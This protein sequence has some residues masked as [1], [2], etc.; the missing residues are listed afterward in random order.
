V[1]NGIFVPVRMVYMTHTFGVR[2]DGNFFM[3]QSKYPRARPPKKLIEFTPNGKR[4]SDKPIIWKVSDTAVGPKF[5]QQG[6]IYSAEQVKPKNQLYPVDLRE[7]LSSKGK[8]AEH[9]AAA[10][11]YGSILK[12]SPKGASVTGA[13]RS[14]MGMSHVALHYCNCENSRFDVDEFGRV[15]YPATVFE[16]ACWTPMGMRSHISAAMATQ[17]AAAP[18]ARIRRSP[19]PK[20]PSPG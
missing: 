15:W 13:L 9:L 17:I 16:S 4:V 12:F 8:E 1:D 6:N 5:D 7:P 2:H 19:N 20:S 14:K 11:M 10:T 3:F 18:A